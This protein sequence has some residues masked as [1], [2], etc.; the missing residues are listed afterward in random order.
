MFL[1]YRFLQ[2]PSQIQKGQRGAK[3]HS[4]MQV[5][6]PA[7][8]SSPGNDSNLKYED[9]SDFDSTPSDMD[10]PENPGNKQSR[11]NSTEDNDVAQGETEQNIN[12]NVF[13]KNIFSNFPP[14]SNIHFPYHLQSGFG[15]SAGLVGQETVY[16][17]PHTDVHYLN[18]NISN[19]CYGVTDGG[20]DKFYSNINNT[21]DTEYHPG[22]VIRPMPSYPSSMGD[23]GAFSHFVKQET[24]LVRAHSTSSNDFRSAGKD[25][26]L[27]LPIDSLYRSQS[28]EFPVK[29]SELVVPYPGHRPGHARSVS[30]RVDL[31]SEPEDLSVKREVDAESRDF[32]SDT[33]TYQYGESN[34]QKDKSDS[35]EYRS[36]HESN[37]EMQNTKINDSR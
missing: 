33:L 19:E 17:S 28:C 5:H 18:S 9:E 6:L 25:R 24:N 36:T 22:K 21:S 35:A 10:S 3:P 16:D 37:E 20:T 14:Y 32:D 27:R 7:T 13:N 34:R 31:Q 26:V 8:V 11:Q 30:P 4:K 15:R 12:K 23:C 29:E 1:N 2:P